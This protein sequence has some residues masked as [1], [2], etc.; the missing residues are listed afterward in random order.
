MAKVTK[1][2]EME[3]EDIP[4]CMYAGDPEDEYCCSCNGITMEL[5]G[6]VF[7]CKECQSYTPSEQKPVEVPIKF[8]IET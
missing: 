4:V 8:L 3:F 1:N 2:K 5:D 7:S 6:Q